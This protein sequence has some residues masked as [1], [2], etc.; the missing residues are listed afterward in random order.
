MLFLLLLGIS[1]NNKNE[2]IILPEGLEWS[3]TSMKSSKK[4]G[5]IIPIPV[6]GGYVLF[7]PERQIR[8]PVLL[9]LSTSWQMPKYE[10]TALNY[11]YFDKSDKMK[12]AGL[13]LDKNF[14]IL[15][16]YDRIKGSGSFNTKSGE[17]FYILGILDEEIIIDAPQISCS[18][19]FQKK[20]DYSYDIISNMDSLTSN[21]SFIIEA[22]P[23]G[24]FGH[25]IPPQDYGPYTK[26]F[27]ICSE[28]ELSHPT[29]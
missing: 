7:N 16:Y 12:T 9:D 8:T 25:L 19:K 10:V 6:D 26:E 21:N 4:T 5:E 29:E 15:K 13:L 20:E 28:E 18:K 1:Q 2:E 14:K 27:N 22:Y 23:P 24:Y 3:V 11:R 17:S